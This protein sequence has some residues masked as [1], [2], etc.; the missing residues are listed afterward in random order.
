[1]ASTRTSGAFLLVAAVFAMAA[2]F[3]TYSVGRSLVE[4]G[5]GYAA[6]QE[7]NAFVDV[8]QYIGTHK[9]SLGIF[10]S[11]IT[12]VNLLKISPEDELYAQAL[13]DA[14]VELTRR[15]GIVREILRVSL[16][17]RNGRILASSAESLIGTRPVPG[18]EKHAVANHPVFTILVPVELNGKTA[19]SIRGE[20]ST[21]GYY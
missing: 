8:E 7:A 21:S 19:G 6:S 13:S 15:A 11:D 18:E 10:A 16:L 17:D 9:H 20:I 12:F 5:S 4:S 2:G 3:F 1:M 14:N